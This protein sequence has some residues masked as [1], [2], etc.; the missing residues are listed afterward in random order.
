MKSSVLL[1]CLACAPWLACAPRTLDDPH[2][3]TTLTAASVPAAPAADPELARAVAAGSG[4]PVLSAVTG[5]VIQ[6]DDAR[7]HALTDAD[8]TAGTPPSQRSP[9]LDYE[10]GIALARRGRT[11]DAVAAYRNAATR[12]AVRGQTAERSI[13]IYGE[14][15]VLSLAH[16]CAEAR[17]A[18]EAYASLVEP[19]SVRDARMARTY[20]N[21]CHADPAGTLRRSRTS[22][23]APRAGHAS[24]P[25]CGVTGVTP[26][27]TA[28]VLLTRRLRPG[29]GLG[30][31]DDGRGLSR[32]AGLA[33][34]AG[35]E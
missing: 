10:R 12:F 19:T 15:E 8:A 24:C 5:A 9:W 26:L 30:R 21:D 29:S 23:R 13:A 22:K 6:G 2:P 35:V 16:R 18:F 3:S 32:H 14:A 11:D 20:A 34:G 31:R 7:V 28:L 4:D 27:G 33:R 1:L 25:C 17:R